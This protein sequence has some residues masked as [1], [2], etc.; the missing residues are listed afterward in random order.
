MRRG[1]DEVGAVTAETAMVLPV[2]VILAVGLAWV[3]ALGVSQV[4]V[5]DAARETARAI[6]R[7]DDRATGEAWGRRVAPA[8]AEFTITTDSGAVRVVVRAQPTGPGGILGFL[9][10]FRAEATAVAALEGVPRPG[11]GSAR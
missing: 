10:G 3:V 4:R 1:R 6:A 9:P 2:L 11:L 7:G 5:V 8:G